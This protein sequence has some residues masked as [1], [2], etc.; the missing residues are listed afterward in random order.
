MVVPWESA[1]R[2]AYLRPCL[3][4]RTDVLLIEDGVGQRMVVYDLCREYQ[5]FRGVTG[6][7]EPG[8]PSWATVDF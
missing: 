4:P 5:Y 1:Q 2:M 6:G 8:E 3:I 7:G